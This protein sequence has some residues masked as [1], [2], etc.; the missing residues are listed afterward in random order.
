M[1]CEYIIFSKY[2]GFQ[3]KVEEYFLAIVLPWPPHI[4]HFHA[5]FILPECCLTVSHT[6]PAQDVLTVTILVKA[7][8]SLI[9]YLAVATSLHPQRSLSVPKHMCDS[10]SPL[11]YSGSFHCNDLLGSCPRIQRPYSVPFWHFTILPYSNLC[12]SSLPM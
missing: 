3:L 5:L 2:L 7:F 4:P 8:S 10:H 11:L 12:I 6:F 9:S 1:L